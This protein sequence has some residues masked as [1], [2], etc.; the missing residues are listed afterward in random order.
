MDLVREK[1]GRCAKLLSSYALRRARNVED[2]V[3]MRP[4]ETP[5]HA[6][7][8]RARNAAAS[9]LIEAAKAYGGQH[10]IGQELMDLH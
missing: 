4:N 8:I 5:D 2:Q 6:H 7:L 10:I 9:A 3:R 1:F